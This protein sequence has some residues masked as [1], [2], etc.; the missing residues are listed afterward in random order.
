MF[1]INIKKN[2]INF[3]RLVGFFTCL[4][5]LEFFSNAFEF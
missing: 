1:V 5:N 2:T 4:L 3:N